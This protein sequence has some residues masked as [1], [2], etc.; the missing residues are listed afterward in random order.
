MNKIILAINKEMEKQGLS[1]TALAKK[2]GLE[3]KKVNRLLSGVTKRLDLEVV[4]GLQGALGIAETPDEE[5]PTSQPRF[6]VV[7][8]IAPEKEKA[9]GPISTALLAFFEALPIEEQ[10]AELQRM[11]AKFIASQ[12]KERP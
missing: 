6:R 11:Q 8:E 1:Q 10:M 7:E 3:Q 9:R 12:S 5:Y 4:S 2:A